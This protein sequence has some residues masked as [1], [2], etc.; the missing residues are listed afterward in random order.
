MIRVGLGYDIHR[1]V[2]ER[3]LVLGG[4]TIPSPFG[5]LGHSDA[6]VALHAVMDALLGAA[7]L[8]DI[9]HHFP[10]SDPAFRNASSLELLGRV[11]ALLESSG[12]RP[13][14]VD[15]V[16]V[17]EQPRIAP[18]AGEMRERTAVALELPVS[19]VSIKATTNEEVGPEGRLEAISARAAALV[20]GA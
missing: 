10:P 2:S 7:C 14:N 13:V 9:G 4:V 18:Y 5:L 11:R 17:A 15:V 19:A 8:G 12:F 1:V 3:P 20:E 6:D 16:I